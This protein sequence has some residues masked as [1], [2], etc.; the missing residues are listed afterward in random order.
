MLVYVLLIV[1]AM[2]FVWKSGR[3]VRTFPVVHLTVSCDDLM[4]GVIESKY[5]VTRAVDK[6]VSS[7]HFQL[8]PTR[9]YFKDINSI[10][11]M[12]D[13]PRSVELSI[14]RVVKVAWL[15]QGCERIL[16]VW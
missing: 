10:E 8:D 16:R 9:K 14:S 13:R 1:S 7:H 12:Q 11:V 3:Q 2:N 5:L 15:C 6:W 4:G